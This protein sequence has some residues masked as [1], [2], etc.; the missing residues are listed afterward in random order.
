MFGRPFWEVAT[1]LER[2]FAVFSFRWLWSLGLCMLALAAT[3]GRAQAPAELKGVWEPV[4]YGEDLQLTDAFFVT[5]ET[6]YVAGAG[7]TILKTTDAGSTWTPLLGGD[8]ASA[9]SPV[10]HLRF[11]SPTTGWATQVTATH[12][13]LFYTRDGESWE[14]IGSIEEHYTDLAFTSDTTGVFAFNKE[15]HQTND[16]GKTWQKAYDCEVK[17]QVDGLA[18]TLQC[19]VIKMH[20]VSTGV[21]F[22]MA[23]AE[24]G[25]Y[26]LR[27]A[28]GGAS[29][30]LASVIEK[31]SAR[32]AGLFFLDENTGYARVRSGKSYRTSD[33]G[34][35]WTGMAATTLG[36][37]VRFA[38]P[39]VG[40][41]FQDPCTGMG[42]E[43]GKL[44][45]TTDGGKRW[46]SRSIAFP[47]PVQSFSFPRRD[48]GYVIGDHGMIYR[49]RVLPVDA[50]I[51]ANAIAAIAMPPLANG[52]IAQI[53]EMEAGLDG[54]EEAV[55]GAAAE[56][57]ADPTEDAT[58]WVEANVAEF[59]EFEATVDTVA[60][61]LPEVGRRH[62]NLNLV[63][64]GLRLLG[65]LTGQGGGLKDAFVTLRE[66]KDPD[67]VSAALVG[68]HSQLDA[69]RTS[70][71]AFESSA[72][73]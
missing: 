67:S 39:E 7:G 51:V 36:M 28:D 71:A 15:V 53:A 62:R 8:P 9:E 43:N 40:W 3:L 58:G 11:V 45:Y 46:A 26:I 4:N 57:S 34:R 22:A 72:P 47:A 1:M 32:N 35:T 70:V 42:C 33:G 61:G 55:A 31:E 23:Y 13:N 41:S 68:L 17:A 38:D 52:V 49:Y 20:F 24:G 5:P 73:P 64:E 10:R 6:G 2:G 29:W 14:Q 66:A 59:S 21:G 48:V 56:P 69:A 27:T 19:E 12:T 30:S 65:D 44:I 25:A 63:L 16:S 54:I 60:S 50:P 18:R 37:S